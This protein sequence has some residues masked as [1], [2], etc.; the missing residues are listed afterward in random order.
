MHTTGDFAKAVQAQARL[1]LLHALAGCLQHNLTQSC[2]TACAVAGGVLA[3]FGIKYE[4][5]AGYRM[6]WR[7]DALVAA[8][9]LWLHTMAGVTDLAVV[10]GDEPAM[11]LGHVV[12]LVH[13]EPHT[14]V[15]YATDPP[16]AATVRPNA[17]QPA[18]A[19]LTAAAA[20]NMAGF[21]AYLASEPAAAPTRAAV[22]QA[23]AAAL[24]G[25]RSAA[26]AVVS[27]PATSV[28]VLRALWPQAPGP[29]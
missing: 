19:V 4:T 22:A 7:D 10:R 2:M 8:P 17:H 6:A 15:V 20:D 27:L 12:P 3:A 16:D 24:E 18:Q 14:E 21:L 1:A 26:P 29:Q 13:G 11:V 28:E 9:H 23:V 25:A 5:R